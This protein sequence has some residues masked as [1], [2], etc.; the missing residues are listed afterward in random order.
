MILLAPAFGMIK[1]WQ[2]KMTPEQLQQWQNQGTLPVYHY[3]AGRELPLHYDFLVDLRSY[4]DGK[5]TRP[6]PTLIIHGNL[7]EVVPIA[8]SET[9]AQTR[10]WVRL[11]PVADDHSLKRDLPLIWQEI[12]TFLE[13]NPA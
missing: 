3:G 8:V 6:V 7:D 12:C 1:Y 4:D 11:V 9:Y 13:L 10:P 5:L 2:D